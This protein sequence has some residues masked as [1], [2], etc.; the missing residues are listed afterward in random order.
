[1]LDLYYFA[2]LGAN[3]DS[4]NILLDE[5]EDVVYFNNL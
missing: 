5:K 2:S 1:M 4:Y 3:F